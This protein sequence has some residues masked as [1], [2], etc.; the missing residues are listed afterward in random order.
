MSDVSLSVDVANEVIHIDWIDDK[1]DI[2]T[3]VPAGATVTVTSSDSSVVSAGTASPA[4]GGGLDASLTFRKAGTATL[5]VQAVD[6]GGANM[7]TSDTINL[8]LTP[9]GA[10]GI[11]VKVANQPPVPAPNPAPAPAPAPGPAPAPSPSP[12]PAPAP[13]PGPGPVTPPTPGPAPAPAPGP[14]NINPP[15]Q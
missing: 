7:G 11:M 5:T 1:G 12:A 2:T 3:D 14:T 15:G 4:S 8:T 9:G 6:G 10:T 13:S